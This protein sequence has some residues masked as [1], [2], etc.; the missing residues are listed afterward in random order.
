MT[1][2][3]LMQTRILQCLDLYRNLDIKNDYILR[4]F[5]GCI[6]YAV[7]LLVTKAEPS[8]TDTA[9]LD[10]SVIPKTILRTNMVLNILFI[11]IYTSQIYYYLICMGFIIVV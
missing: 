6:I 10:G 7:L 3:W 5:L 2:Y 1:Y 11:I 9:A 4:A 8:D